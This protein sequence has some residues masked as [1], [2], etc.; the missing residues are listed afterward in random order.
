MTDAKTVDAAIGEAERLA[1]VWSENV[2]FSIGDLTLDG[3]KLEIDKL[4]NLKHSRDESR[5]RLSKL[6]D[7]TNDQK[8]LIEGINSRGRSGMRASFGPD[9]AQYSQVGGTRASKRKPV[10]RR[11]ARAQPAP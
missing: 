6:V 5:V 10:A 1:Q 8:K 3:F 9:S 7:D 4:R 2:N 11:K